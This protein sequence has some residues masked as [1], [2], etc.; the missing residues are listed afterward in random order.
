MRDSTKDRVEGT[1]HEVKG[2]RRREAD[3]FLGG[4]YGKGQIAGT[5]P[6]YH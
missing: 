2:S 6:S 4:E 5:W 1:Y 3:P